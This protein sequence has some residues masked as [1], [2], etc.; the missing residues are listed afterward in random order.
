MSV[1]DS[2]P[3]SNITS[4]SSHTV[5]GFFIKI[6]SN[7][8]IVETKGFESHICSELVKVLTAITFNR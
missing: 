3:K 4:D 7:R 1:P 2:N 5:C 8:I 6:L